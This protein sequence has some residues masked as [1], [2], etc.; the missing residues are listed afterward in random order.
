MPYLLPTS[1]P[2]GL[3]LTPS[4]GDRADLPPNPIPR[5]DKMNA[6]ETA[7]KY[8][9]IIQR[10]GA[11]HSAKDNDLVQ[12]M[13]DRACDLGAKCKCEEMGT[14]PLLKARVTRIS[15]KGRKRK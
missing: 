9:A 7:A 1:G 4:M 13:H 6:Y 11:R 5:K 10:A 15:Q 12:Q 2:S 8:M 3:C 14:H